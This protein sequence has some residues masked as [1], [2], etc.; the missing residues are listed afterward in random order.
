MPLSTAAAATDADVR[1][2]DVPGIRH[3]FNRI[4]MSDEQVVAGDNDDDLL[5][6]CRLIFVNDRGVARYCVGK[7]ERGDVID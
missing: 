4:I 1:T 6:R 7:C 3:S 5:R 2:D